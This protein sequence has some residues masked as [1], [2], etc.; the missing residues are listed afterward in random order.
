MA[1]AKNVL[2]FKVQLKV[3]AVSTKPYPSKNVL[4]ENVL[5]KRY[6]SS[7]HRSPINLGDLG[8]PI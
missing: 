8:S 1:K 4:Q 2:Y 3:C 7:I 5:Q 6:L